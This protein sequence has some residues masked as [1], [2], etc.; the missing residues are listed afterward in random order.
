ML[1]MSTLYR[2]SSDN[3]SRDSS[4]VD[5]PLD[6]SEDFKEVSSLMDDLHSF[7]LKLQIHRETLADMLL[8]EM[9]KVEHYC[10][11][12][13]VYGAQ[14]KRRLSNGEEKPEA[15]SVCYRWQIL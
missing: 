2:D 15:G 1:G 10:L 3:W 13:G 4:V 5:T 7:A 14:S 8:D 12:H 11:C 9:A 6:V